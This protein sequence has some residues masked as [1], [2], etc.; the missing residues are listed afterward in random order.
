MVS[1]ED[2]IQDQLIISCCI[3]RVS[4]QPHSYDHSGGLISRKTPVPACR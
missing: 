3:S 4:A 1:N 2:G